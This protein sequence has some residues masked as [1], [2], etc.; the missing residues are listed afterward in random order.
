MEIKK[1]VKAYYI[2]MLCPQCGKAYM[3]DDSNGVVLATS[4]PQYW[5]KCPKC[6]YRGVY[7]VRY[8]YLS[9]EGAEKNGGTVN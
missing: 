9:F 6:N 4:P 7:N 2:Y 1:P 5:H 3:E 8:P